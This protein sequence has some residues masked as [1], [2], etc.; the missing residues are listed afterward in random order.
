MNVLVTRLQVCWVQLSYPHLSP[1]FLSLPYLTKAFNC[2]SWTKQAWNTAST[3]EASWLQANS[4]QPMNYFRL[5]FV[6]QSYSLQ[7]LLPS[8]PDSKALKVI[9]AVPEASRKQSVSSKSTYEQ[10][11]PLPWSPDPVSG[12][13]SCPTLLSSQEEAVC[14][15]KNM[16]PKGRSPAMSERAQKISGAKGTQSYTI[17]N[18]N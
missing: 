17:H 2:L 5:L 18:A 1:L 6:L 12:G 7:S 14:N 8:C 4:Q 13:S 15:T 16:P 3:T 11:G 10:H 9:L